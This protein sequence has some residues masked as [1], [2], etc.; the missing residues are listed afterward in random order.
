M[1][2]VKISVIMPVYNAELYLRE[3]LESVKNQTFKNFELIAV[4]DG[5]TDSS[6]KI[7]LEY[8]NICNIKIINQNNSGV[9]RARNVGISKSIGAYI[10]FLDADDILSPNYL[11]SLY[12]C[13][14]NNDADMAFC[15]YITFY[16]RCDF[17]HKK[18]INVYTL[19]EKEASK[20]FDYLMERGLATSPCNKIFKKKLLDCYSISFNENVSYGED[21]FFNWKAVLASNKVVGTEADLY[22]YRLN[23]YGATVKYHSD[24]FEKYMSELDD[25]RNFGKSINSNE[26]LLEKSI[27]LNLLKLVPSM[28]RMT[29]RKKNNIFSKYSNV[30]KLINKNEIQKAVLLWSKE[31][32]LENCI[33]QSVLE[34]KYFSL[35]ICSIKMEYR[36]RIGRF[37]KNLRCK[38]KRF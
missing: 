32:H 38:I 5:S 14:Y 23:I 3:T 22:G 29:I 7:L 2:N 15:N 21:L 9:S 37:I 36:F 28:L 17:K 16:G 10:C 26:D 33:L 8:T 34:K 30:K 31:T 1:N 12:D 4:N 35:F 11:Q 24:M 25:V 6:E 19:S 18:D 27:N 20:R 13:I